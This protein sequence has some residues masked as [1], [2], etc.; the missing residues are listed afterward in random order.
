MYHTSRLSGNMKSILLMFASA[1][2][3]FRNIEE[4]NFGEISYEFFTERMFTLLASSMAAVCCCP[5][6]A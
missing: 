2:F 4:L 5:R 6:G 1:L 3:L